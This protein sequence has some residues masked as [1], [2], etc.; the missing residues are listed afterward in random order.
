MGHGSRSPLP[1]A[2]EVA[3]LA[4]THDGPRGEVRQDNF[5]TP[6]CGVNRD[7]PPRI[8]NPE[9]NRVSVK[10]AGCGAT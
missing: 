6:G 2:I 4:S 8:V 5:A 3:A 1:H 9:M 10:G 7:S